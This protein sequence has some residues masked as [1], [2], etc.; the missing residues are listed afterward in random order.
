WML[1]AA[2][3]T[4]ESSLFA[5]A[6]PSLGSKVLGEKFIVGFL[7]ALVIASGVALAGDHRNALAIFGCAILFYTV[8]SS[9]VDASVQ[10][11]LKVPVFVLLMAA[12]DQ[13]D[14]VRFVFQSFPFV[15]ALTS[16]VISGLLIRRELSIDAARSRVL[17]QPPMANTGT[18]TAFA[19]VFGGAREG[20]RQPMPVGASPGSGS[21]IA[22][23]RAAHYENFGARRF[24]WAKWL[25]FS[26][27]INCAFAYGL[28][29]ASFAAMMGLMY[30]SLQGHRLRGRWLYPISRSSRAN[31]N[32]FTSLL[33]SAT[34]FL[35]AAV[36]MWLL[37][38]SG[39]PRFS[40]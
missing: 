25:L 40:W 17:Y 4:A 31:L 19:N 34:Y 9:M 5:F 16:L 2:A 29:N 35:L 23:I 24:G 36:A 14:R 18:G 32:V 37:D 3:R 39:L 21:M 10:A 28:G 11:R 30:L 38:L 13:W 7:L 22:W 15:S 20:V 33:D 6:V 1:S 12:A 8:V 27:A 26:V